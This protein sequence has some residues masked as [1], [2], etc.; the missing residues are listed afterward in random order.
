MTNLHIA[1]I[2]GQIFDRTSNRA[3]SHILVGKRSLDDAMLQ[4]E[5]AGLARYVADNY[6]YYREYLDGTSRYLE[7]KSWERD[8]AAFE[9]RVARDLAQAEKALEGCETLG[10]YR[11]KLRAAAI[12]AVQSGK[13][14]GEYD[15]WNDLGWASRLDLATKNLGTYASKSQWKNLRVIPAEV[16]TYDNA[17]QARKALKTLQA[18]A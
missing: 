6:E 7:R 16:Y 14:K 3:Y 18:A 11:E 4:A 15:T 12:A 13:A 2:D 17:S 8:D 1:R 10:D 5:R 9:A